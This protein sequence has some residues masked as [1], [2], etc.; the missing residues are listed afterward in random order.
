MEAM[1]TATTLSLI[2][3]DPRPVH[4]LLLLVVAS[5]VVAA[6]VERLLREVDSSPWRRRVREPRTAIAILCGMLVGTLLGPAVFGRLAPAL[7]ED[8]LLGARAERES[9]VAIERELTAFTHAARAA[10]TDAAVIE[11]DLAPRWAEQLLADDRYRQAMWET[12]RPARIAVVLLAI[13]IL[14]SGCL[15]VR[16]S[17]L[18]ASDPV[19]PIAPSGE[20]APMP[21][22]ATRRHRVADAVTIGLFGSSVASLLGLL[23]LWL[24]EEPVVTPA[25][26]IT[27]AALSVG[28][29][30]VSPEAIG[31]VERHEP[32]GG[33]VVRRAAA[34]ATGAAAV[35]LGA[36]FWRSSA[37]LGSEAGMTLLA[38]IVA[39]GGSAC[40]GLFR[41]Q[42][43]GVG[44]VTTTWARR[45]AL[46]ALPALAAL[47]TSRIEWLLDFSIA[48]FILLPLLSS[49]GRSAGFFLGAVA[50][51]GRRFP[52]WARVMIA[53][54]AT[55]PTQ[56]AV[57]AVGLWLELL[58]EWLGAGLLLGV[59][60]IECTRWLR[61]AGA[62]AIRVE[63]ARE[64]GERGE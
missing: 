14:G 56:L 34:V 32:G 51:G 3:F 36:I 43:P 23:A 57:V 20:A 25:A 22:A 11:S 42:A 64:R 13:V 1:V 59:A 63:E 19:A 54:A 47:A 33:A 28:S 44:E 9:L 18:E 60:L 35:L 7:A 39:L 26:F 16:G 15:R 37:A 10:G 12:Q 29:W 45:L 21:P 61:R 58:S 8:L 49:D 4:G 46:G 53:S 17:L 24:W 31:I 52:G 2:T 27:L 55:G 5:T 6:L 48:P 38:V 41:R 62:V 30:M 40:V 50:A